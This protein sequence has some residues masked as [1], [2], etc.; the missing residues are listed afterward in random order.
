MLFYVFNSLFT[1]RPNSADLTK[2]VW[3][4]I[5]NKN[6]SCAYAWVRLSQRNVGHQLSL[7]AILFWRRLL[8]TAMK[9]LDG[10]RYFWFLKKK[11]QIKKFYPVLV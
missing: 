10:N 11:K 8:G 6:V 1:T 2:A 9:A 3:R 4:N 7:R 5:A